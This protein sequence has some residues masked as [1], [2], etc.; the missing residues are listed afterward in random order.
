M[1]AS[2]VIASR[3]LGRTAP[4][5]SVGCLLVKEGAVVGQGY[6][7]I[8]GRP[9][10]ETKALRVAKEKAEGAT[11]FI[12][13]E[14]CAHENNGP[15]CAEQLVNCGIARA[16]IAMKDPDPRTSGKGLQLLIDNDID[17]KLDV[18]RKMAYRI[19][20]GHLCRIKYNRPTISLKI[21]TSLDGRIA[22][23]K[24]ESKW[25]TGILA[26][27]H[28]HLIRSF[29][30]AILVGIETVKKDDPM[31]NC[32]LEGLE[33]YSPIRVIL[34][35]KLSISLESKLLKSATEI[36][37]WI[38][39]KKN[40]NIVK[41]KE[42]QKKGAKII[43]ISESNNGKLDL[44]HLLNVLSNKGI[45]RLLVEGGSKVNASFISLGLVDD[46]LC[47]RSGLLLGHEGVSSIFNLTT[48]KLNLAPKF[49]FLE[50][51]KLGEDLLDIWTEKKY[52]NHF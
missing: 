29:Y 6:T 40:N 21:A 51:K 31:L 27:R 24:G 50:Q 1:N 10:A 7:D 9:H 17:V 36:P 25:I 2:I 42:L 15:S 49:E 18:C 20:Y 5:P 37:L 11:A 30:D 12:T 16:V 28:A 52:F 39:T 43:E 41:Q 4:N 23:S 44:N 26:R 14:P 35:S 32:R 47:Y 8:G 34:D 48:D 3:G 46:I 13:L 22:T 33:K 38:V 19:N 45:T